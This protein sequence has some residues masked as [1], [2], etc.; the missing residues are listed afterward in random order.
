MIQEWHELTGRDLTLKEGDLIGQ[1]WST[2]SLKWSMAHMN[3]LSG[4][5][6]WSSK[7]SGS[8]WKS[9]FEESFNA[10]MKVSQY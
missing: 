8:I 9:I 7:S 3:S 1:P 4:E 10:E 5:L 2:N 6:F